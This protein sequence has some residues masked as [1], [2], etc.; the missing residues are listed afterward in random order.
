[1][2]MGKNVALDR[3]PAGCHIAGMWRLAIGALLVGSVAFADKPKVSVG[4]VQVVVGTFDVAP[5][6]KIAKTAQAKVLKC[7][8]DHV[9]GGAGTATAHMKLA[10]DG[11]VTSVTVTG[12][13][14]VD[15]APV[16]NCI[17]D[18][19][20]KLKFA[21]PKA[22]AVVDLSVAFKF[23]G[24]DAVIGGILGDEVGEIN[25]G[26]GSGVFG[27]G[28]GGVGGTIGTGR[29]G[30]IGKGGGTGVGVG[31]TRPVGPTVSLGQA[32]QS[33]DLDKALIRRY[34]RRNIQ[35]IQYCYEKELL[36]SPQ[37]QGTVTAK[38][39]IA[40]SGIVTVSTASGLNA[41]VES[42]VAAAINA[43]EFPK[44]KGGE[45]IVSYPFTFMPAPP[46]PKK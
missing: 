19:L 5:A 29:Y 11:K 22:G 8:V 9:G 36:A 7:Y 1:M 33:G 12:L 21:A 38:F 45:V 35:K 23:S 15:A 16:H 27:L 40:P 3:D 26:R 28:G 13:S 44:P 41:N 20:G 25:G 42:C 46:A 2:A 10:V 6:T 17:A 14:N 39:T 37:L 4:T 32:T 31:G 24:G 18:A 30:T 43:I 34:I